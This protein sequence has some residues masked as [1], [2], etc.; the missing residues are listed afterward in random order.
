MIHVADSNS[1]NPISL[2]SNSIRNRKDDGFA[3]VKVYSLAS[4]SAF[5]SSS[6]SHFWVFWSTVLRK[7]LRPTLSLRSPTHRR[8]LRRTINLQRAK[9]DGRINMSSYGYRLRT[10]TLTVISMKG[11]SRHLRS[12]CGKGSNF[13]DAWTW[14]LQF[15]AV[16]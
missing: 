11:K 15:I 8:R 1:W 12:H 6:K 13:P 10:S 7:R 3:I 16:V 9:L 4:V 2:G 14:F 5:T